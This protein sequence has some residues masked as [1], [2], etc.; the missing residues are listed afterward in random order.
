MHISEEFD[1]LYTSDDN[2]SVIKF[3]QSQRS[4]SYEYKEKCIDSLGTWR[5]ADAKLER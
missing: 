5:E 2:M 4:V 1:A 3:S